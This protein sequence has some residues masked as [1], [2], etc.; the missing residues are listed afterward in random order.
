MDGIWGYGVLMYH[1]H[2]QA[3]I[4]KS[5]V[6]LSCVGGSLTLY[7]TEHIQQNKTIR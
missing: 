1:T 3:V 2:T 4:I 5:C 6:T 7:A